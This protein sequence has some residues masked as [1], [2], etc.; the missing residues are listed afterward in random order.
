MPTVDITDETYVAVRPE[1]LAPQLTAPALLAAWFPRL[2][3]EVFMD[4]GEKGTRWSVTGEID[5]SLEVWLEPTGR[6]TLIHW[7]ARGE[8]TVSR[9]DM[10]RRYV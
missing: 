1:A 3:F 6:G 2:S 8:P 5:G 9:G 10:T 7:F 4:R